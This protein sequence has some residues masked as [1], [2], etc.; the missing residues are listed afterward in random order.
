LM[1]SLRVLRPEVRSPSQRSTATG[2]S[3]S[4]LVSSSTWRQVLTLSE[5]KCGLPLALSPACRELPPTRVDLEALP[6]NGGEPLSKGPSEPRRRSAPSPQPPCGD[7]ALEPRSQDAAVTAVTAVTAANSSREE[8][9]S[10]GRCRGPCRPRASRRSR[11]N[12]LP[13]VPA[14]GSFPLPLPRPR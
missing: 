3:Q 10:I 6:V 11:S 7:S 12:H 2:S 13:R 5:F 8:G 1:L 9:R 14:A 4:G